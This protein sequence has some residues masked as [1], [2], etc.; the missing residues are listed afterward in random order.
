MYYRMIRLFILFILLSIGLFILRK[1]RFSPKFIRMSF[2]V[3]ACVLCALATIPVENLFVT[4]DSPIDAFHYR[5]SGDVQFIINGTDSTFV[6]ASQNDVNKTTAIIPKSG[7]GWKIERD[8]STETVNN[9]VADNNVIIVRHYKKTQDYYIEIGSSNAVEIWDSKGS[10][11]VCDIT[12]TEPVLQS[13]GKN[14]YYTYYSYINNLNSEYELY[15][16][17]KLITFD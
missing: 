10:E 8:F 9:F 15:I 14:D 5:N 3:A 13:N 2:A 12:S 6:V 1:K 11:F 4:F 16:A 7:Q 17:G